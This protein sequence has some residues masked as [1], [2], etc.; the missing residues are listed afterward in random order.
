MA[1]EVRQV[2]PA[3]APAGNFVVMHGPVLQGFRKS[4]IR[5]RHVP[6]LPIVSSSAAPTSDALPA[7][8]QAVCANSCR[9]LYAEVP[10]SSGGAAA[11]G[12]FTR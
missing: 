3:A 5:L 12:A 7:M 11:S 10:G 9:T 4:S 2:P 8:D 1:P 6:H